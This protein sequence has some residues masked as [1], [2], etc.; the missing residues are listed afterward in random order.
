[1]RETKKPFV[2]PLWLRFIDV[3]QGDFL[4]AVEAE[5]QI[6]VRER[7]RHDVHMRAAFDSANETGKTREKPSKEKLKPCLGKP[8]IW[9]GDDQLPARHQ[10]LM[11]CFEEEVGIAE[12]LNALA[13][14]NGL[15]KSQVIGKTH[16]EVDITKQTIACGGGGE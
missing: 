16:V 11:C 5:E 3:M 13:T 14:H 9:C 6:Q 7:P 8:Y 2:K 1:M 15:I 4:E 10:T 12:V